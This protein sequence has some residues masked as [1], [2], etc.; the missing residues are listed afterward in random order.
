VSADHLVGQRTLLPVPIDGRDSSARRD[1]PRAWGL[2]NAFDGL[3]GKDH[4]ES[5][6]F[7]VEGQVLDESSR[8]PSTGGH[9]SGELGFVETLYRG[10]DVL[11][12]VLEGIRHD[13]EIVHLTS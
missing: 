8:G 2:A 7:D 12:L 1:V 11:A 9:Q 10:E 13:V 3:A 6:A 5:E 4:P